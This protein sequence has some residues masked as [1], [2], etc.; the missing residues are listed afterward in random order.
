MNACDCF[1]KNPNAFMLKKWLIFLIFHHFNRVSCNLARI[2]YLLCKNQSR[3]KYNNL[4]TIYQFISFFRT[5]IKHFSV[6]LQHILFYHS[7]L[8]YIKI[9]YSHSPIIISEHFNQL[10]NIVKRGMVL[11][12]S[13][14]QCLLVLFLNDSRKYCD[15]LKFWKK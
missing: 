9:T 5:M 13:V 10:H 12:N 6:F 1:L 8:K 7:L 2:L 15:K 4:R 14:V 3:C 11:S